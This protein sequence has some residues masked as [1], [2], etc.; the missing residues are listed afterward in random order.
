M[1]TRSAAIRVALW[2]HLPGLRPKLQAALAQSAPS[3][4]KAVTFV[5][6]S[7][8]ELGAW[9]AARNAVAAAAAAGGAGVGAG[10][11]AGASDSSS[12]AAGESAI[13]SR[14]LSDEHLKEL[15]TAE[16]VLVD[17]PSFGPFIDQATS[18]R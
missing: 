1:T 18:M 8:E 12:A 3:V 9:Q 7:A 17:P 15:A 5:G 6:P 2:S 14:S 13:A 11:G 4:A 10:G 16:V